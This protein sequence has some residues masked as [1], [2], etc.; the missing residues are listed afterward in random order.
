[1][2]KREGIPQ[3]FG[4]HAEKDKVNFA[5]QVPRGQKCELLLYRAGKNIPEIV[6]E[7]PEEEGIGEV[8]YLAVEGKNISRYEYNYRI[9][10]KVCMDPYVK[11]I[12][13][14]KAFG[15]MRSGER[16]FRQDMTGMEINGSIS[17]GMRWWHT[18]SMSGGSRNTVLR[19]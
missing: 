8:R 11:E 7:M 4:A 12:A 14:K 19:K 5:V 6:F 3:P 2:I 15:I 9:N 16:S 17:P 10:K 1:M 18:A 13:G